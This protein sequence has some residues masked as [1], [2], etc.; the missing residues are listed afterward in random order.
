MSRPRTLLLFSAI[1]ACIPIHAQGLEV[2]AGYV[3]Q[4]LKVDYEGGG[5]YSEQRRSAGP[6]FRAAWDLSGADRFRLQVEGGWMR[7]AYRE[8]RQDSTLLGLRGSWWSPEGDGHA[9]FG[10]EFRGERVGSPGVEA[11]T[12]GRLWARAGLGFRG[13]L[14]PLFPWDTA[15]TLRG[16]ARF[17]PFTRVVA[18]WGLGSGVQ[19]GPAHSNREFGLEIGLRI[20]LD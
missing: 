13:I 12:R 7:N 6:S 4:G 16:T 17:I 19:S 14:V 9:L 10:V 11:V 5:I 20:N 15:M 2:M 1:Q 3:D 18:G 8:A